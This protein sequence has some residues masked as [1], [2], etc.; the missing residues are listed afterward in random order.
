MDAIR[1]AI[2][3]LASH[4][5]PMTVRQIFYRL[6]S[7]GL[8]GKTEAEYKS[9]VC[10]LCSEMRLGGDLPF[11]WIADNSR[12]MRKPQSYS[13]LHSMLAITKSAYRRDLWTSQPEYV[14]IWLEKEALSGVLYEVTSEWDVPLMVTRGYPSLTF[15]H[16]A[17]MA[18]DDEK[19]T[20]L[21]FFGDY[22]PSGLDIARNVEERLEELAD[23][24]FVFERVAVTPEQVDLWK[25]P[26]R[27]TKTTDTR[28]RYF[29]GASVEVDA[30][31]PAHLRQLVRGCIEHHV[32]HERLA[33]MQQIEDEERRLLEQIY[34]LADE[35]EL[36][37]SDEDEP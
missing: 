7:E 4:E 37:G 28:S 31:P 30:I 6:V 14:E 17:A 18:M 36:L 21:Y 8:V 2:Y 33:R 13:G 15:L 1:D 10:R 19:P 25:L 29:K 22:D 34:A 12:W 24:E 32:D 20:Y 11:H 26:T 27:P 5:H 3:G 16:E 9:T 23:A 35:N